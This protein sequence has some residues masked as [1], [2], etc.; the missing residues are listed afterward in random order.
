[1]ASVERKGNGWAVRW[2]EGG[3]GGRHKQI[4]VSTERRAQALAEE[5]EE[6]L[7]RHGR[8]EPRKAGR[9]SDFALILTEYVADVARRRAPS[10]TKRYAQ[11][12][13]GFRRFVGDALVDEALSF[14]VLSDYHTHLSDPKTGRHLHAR[15]AE[16]VRKHIEAIELLWRWAWQ[17]R[18]E[19]E[20]AAWRA[21]REKRLQQQPPEGA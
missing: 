5:I 3:R 20:D 15:S 16:T 21:R 7:E 13:E 6:A 1:M 18:L 2:W 8:Y 11:M 14:E 17:R 12:L 4:T 9:A 10:T 19:Q